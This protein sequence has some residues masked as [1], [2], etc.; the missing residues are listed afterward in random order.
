MRPE[1]DELVRIRRFMG[2]T[3]YAHKQNGRQGRRQLNVLSARYV[4]T[5]VTRPRFQKTLLL[6][7]LV[8]VGVALGGAGQN[9]L[10]DQA[11]VLADRHLDLRGHVRVGLQERL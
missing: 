1:P 5:L 4:E 2:S 6:R 7:R 8:A 9:L 10:G 11:G 3:R